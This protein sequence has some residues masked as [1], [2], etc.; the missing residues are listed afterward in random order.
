[1]RC[2][3]ESKARFA[4]D[5]PSTALNAVGNVVIIRAHTTVAKR[6]SCSSCGGF[7]GCLHSCRRLRSDRLPLLE[8][9]LLGDAAVFC[10][11]SV[12]TLAQNLQS[13]RQ[14]C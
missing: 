12:Q 9:P 5:V 2:D 13:L 8:F 11:F 10:F 4:H 6:C 7:F 1:L 14:S 3:L